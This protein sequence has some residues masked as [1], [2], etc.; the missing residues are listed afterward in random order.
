MVALY[1]LYLMIYE[2]LYQYLYDGLI[3]F[4]LMNVDLIIG[5]SVISLAHLVTS[6]II[7]MVAF[8]VAIFP[9]SLIIGIA[10]KVFRL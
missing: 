7:L 1:D 3:L 2:N 8:A 4:P 6:I 10:K 9:I 5:V